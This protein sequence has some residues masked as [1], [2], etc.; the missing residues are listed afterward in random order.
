SMLT[1]LEAC[2]EQEPDSRGWHTS[3][4]RPTGPTEVT[5]D[6]RGH[7]YTELLT[8][9]AS[10]AV[11]SNGRPSGAESIAS[12]Q[13]LNRSYRNEAGQVTQADQYFNLS[14]LTYSTSPNLGTENTDY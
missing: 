12:L 8:M 10:P 3:T 6:D 5:R 14:G 11:D 2:I 7:G 9:S 13:T 1:L 4:N